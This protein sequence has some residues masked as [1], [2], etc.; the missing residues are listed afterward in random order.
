MSNNMIHQKPILVSGSHRSGSTWVGK[1]LALSPSVGYINEPFNLG[2]R[3]HHPGIC[4]AKFDYWFTYI[5][6]EN[7]SIFYKDIK[8]TINF[9]YKLKK[10]LEVIK[11]IKGTGRMLLD[12]FNFSRYSLT[13]ARPLVKDPIAIFSAEWLAAKFDMKVVILI[14]HPAAFVSS[15]KVKQWSFPFSD[16]LEQQLL[17]RDHLYPFESEIQEYAQQE[18][19]IIEQGTLLWK[20]VHHLIIKYQEKYQNWL[21]IRHEDLSLEPVTM[22]Q[23][24]YEKLDLDFSESILKQIN[25]YSGSENPLETYQSK[26]ELLAKDSIKRDSRANIKNWQ[27][28][29]SQSE[30]E[31]IRN[32][33]EDISKVFYS[34][35]DWE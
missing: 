22:F 29:L 5:T 6:D 16:L 21:F 9:S 18:H 34:D 31:Q 1:M 35:I 15:L 27:N 19:S 17:M 13:N 3:Q 23:T 10:E 14:R 7:E 24:L 25:Q 28:R 2:H 11:S 8:D 33:V 26:A 30:I 20:I 12:Y 32:K 4:S